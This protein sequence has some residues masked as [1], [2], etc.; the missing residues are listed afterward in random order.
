MAIDRVIDH[1]G[2][3]L[4]PK[5]EGAKRQR[6]C[7]LAMHPSGPGVFAILPHDTRTMDPNYLRHLE[8]WG[9]HPA[10]VEGWVAKVDSQ[11][12][13]QLPK[14]LHEPSI[15]KSGG[16]ITFANI[17]G[18]NF[19]FTAPKREKRMAAIKAMTNLKLRGPMAAESRIIIPSANTINAILASHEAARRGTRE[20]QKKLRFA[21]HRH[22][23]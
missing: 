12:R 10:S 19:I 15:P 17:G 11:G 1:K 14:E 2:R 7:Y 5:V 21:K 4:L 18:V 13:M 20:H 6:A 23:K 8:I 3:V 9:V 22:F 16:R